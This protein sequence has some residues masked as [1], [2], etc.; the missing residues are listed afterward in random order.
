MELIGVLFGIFVGA[1][2]N[3]EPHWSLRDGCKV[4]TVKAAG[5]NYGYESYDSCKS[6]PR[7]YGGKEW[8]PSE[9][10]PTL[11]SA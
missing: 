1:N 4:Q 2:L 11:P 9:S 8:K 5:G 7:V 6:L 10:R 3:T